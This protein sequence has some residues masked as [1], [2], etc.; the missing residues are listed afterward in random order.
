VV[1]D[2]EMLSKL[3]VVALVALRLELLVLIVVVA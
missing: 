1:A 3:V 2:A